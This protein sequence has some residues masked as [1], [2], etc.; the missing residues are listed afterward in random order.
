[1]ECGVCMVLTTNSSST[2]GGRELGVDAL[3]HTYICFIFVP[4]NCMETR[5]LIAGCIINNYV[6]T[7]T[8]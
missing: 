5:M 4:H 7:F 2:A 1:M 3:W 6:F 8:H